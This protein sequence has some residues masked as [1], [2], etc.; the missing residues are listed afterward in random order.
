MLWS[1][2]NI[3]S[4]FNYCDDTYDITGFFT[5]PHS[6]HCS[7]LKRS[8][9]VSHQTKDI[10][11]LQPFCSTLLYLVN[12]FFFFLYLLHSRWMHHN[13]FFL[14]FHSHHKNGVWFL[15]SVYFRIDVIWFYFFT[16]ARNYCL[17][18]TTCS[19]W[20]EDFFSE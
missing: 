16:Q 8:N 9:L 4:V 18:R 3:C 14:H 7:K 10:S 19:E 11:Y 20:S 13:S 2:I 6:F 15:F 12:S 17:P 5:I 1:R